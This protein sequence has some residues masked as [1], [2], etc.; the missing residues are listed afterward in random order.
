MFAE[1][2]SFTCVLRRRTCK[3]HILG[4]L[5]PDMGCTISAPPPNQCQWWRSQLAIPVNRGAKC[6]AISEPTGPPTADQTWP[7]TKTIP[8]MNPNESK[9]GLKPA[10]PAAW[11]NWRQVA[12]CRAPKHQ[13]PSKAWLRGR[14][15]TLKAVCCLQ[16]RLRCRMSLHNSRLACLVGSRLD[17]LSIWDEALQISFWKTIPFV[18]CENDT[19]LN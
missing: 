3:H 5:C 11:P 19:H 2:D 12:V 13:G 8:K 9:L 7:P 4:Y 14:D 16:G 15:P 17:K 1:N 6:A 10:R 18:S